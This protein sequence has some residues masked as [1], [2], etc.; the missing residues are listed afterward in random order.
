[1][2]KSF[3]T[4]TITRRETGELSSE[5]IRSDRQQAS[6][7]AVPVGFYGYCTACSQAGSHHEIFGDVLGQ[8]VIMQCP[9]H[10]TEGIALSELREVN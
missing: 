8:S 1:M 6:S 10:G 3:E 5:E 9:T 7:Q 4:F 2:A